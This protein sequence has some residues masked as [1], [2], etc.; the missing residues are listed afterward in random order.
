MEKL[1]GTEN[2]SSAG[3][4]P[5]ARELAPPKEPGTV[6]SRG[7]PEPGGSRRGD[8]RPQAGASPYCSARSGEGRGVGLGQVIWPSFVRETDKAG[9]LKMNFPSDF[10]FKYTF[11]FKKTN[12]LSVGMTNISIRKSNYTKNTTSSLG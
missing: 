9:I 2:S 12:T 7:D 11:F 1:T 5:D 10:I 4:E 3:G 8:C 6:R